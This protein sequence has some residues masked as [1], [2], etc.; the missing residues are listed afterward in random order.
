MQYAEFTTAPPYY[1]KEDSLHYDKGQGIP[2]LRRETMTQDNMLRSSFLLSQDHH[3]KKDVYI[4][5]AGKDLGSDSEVSR[6]FFSDK[7]IRRIQKKIK[8]EVFNKSKGK[9]KLDV[10][11][12]EKD[13]LIAMTSVY[14]LK[15]RFCCDYPIRQVKKLNHDTVNYILPDLI[16]NL[17]QY[18]G[19][20]K[21]L[22]EPL[23]PLPQPINV[24]N[25]G[26]RALP[27]ITT[28][29]GLR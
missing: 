5:Q 17:K 11:Q 22:N 13:L 27:S 3:R 15:A 8:K 14:R 6:I 10:D 28:T 26:R 2:K 21:N 24:N 18:Y 20:L 9:F 16:S 1:G 12:D 25:A 29:F 7:N 4:D 19:Y 23:S